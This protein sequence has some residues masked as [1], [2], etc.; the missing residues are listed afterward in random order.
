LEIQTQ[1]IASWPKTNISDPIINASHVPDL[2]TQNQLIELLTRLAAEQALLTKQVNQLTEELRTTIEK[3]DGLLEL[4][5]K[6][7]ADLKTQAASLK[8]D[9]KKLE[10]AQQAEAKKIA[11]Q[12]QRTLLTKQTPF[13][14]LEPFPYD[15]EKQRVLGTAEP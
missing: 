13:A 9:E 15:T 1:K 5:D 14:T 12:R 8:R 10:R 3:R 4:G 11:A 6:S 7:T 2:V